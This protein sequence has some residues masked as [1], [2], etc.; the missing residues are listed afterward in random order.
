MLNNNE[1]DWPCYT[2]ACN[3]DMLVT[4]P[5]ILIQNV[6]SVGCRTDITYEKCIPECLSWYCDYNDHGYCEA[7]MVLHAFYS[8]IIYQDI[9]SPIFLQENCLNIYQGCTLYKLGDGLC[10]TECNNEW[11]AYDFGDCVYICNK[12]CSKCYQEMGDTYCLECIEGYYL[13]YGRCVSECYIGFQPTTK[14]GIKV[15]EPSIDISTQSN[16]YIIY[17]SQQILKTEDQTGDI[18]HP[19]SSLSTALSYIRYKYTRIYLLNYD[20]S[21]HILQILNMKDFSGSR[22][23]K[24]TS[25]LD[26]SNIVFSKNI[27]IFP[28]QCGESVLEQCY[29]PDSMARIL[30]R[31]L[32]A[33]EF[34]VRSTLS[35]QNVEFDGYNIIVS[36]DYGEESEYLTYC[37]FVSYDPKTG[38][39]F[40]DRGEQVTWNYASQSDC[41][42]YKN[43]TLF[44]LNN[45]TLN[46]TNVTFINWRAG[47]FSLFTGYKPQLF[48]SYVNFINIKTNNQ[49]YSAVLSFYDCQIDSFQCG[50]IRYQY[51]I[52][53]MLNSGYEYEDNNY[54]SGFL[55]SRGI[56]KVR[57]NQVNFEENLVYKGKSV[58]YETY[59]NT[60]TLIYA[61]NTSLFDISYSTFR[62]NIADRLFKLKMLTSYKEHTSTPQPRIE[63]FGNRVSLIKNIFSNI[64]GDIIQLYFYSQLAMITFSECRFE[65]I[66]YNFHLI[67]VRLYGFDNKSSEDGM[68]LFEYPTYLN[69]TE[70]YITRCYG[71]ASAIFLESLKNVNLSS[72]EID[73]SLQPWESMLVQDLIN[74]MVYSHLIALDHYISLP[75]QSNELTTFLNH[76]ENLI[77]LYNLVRL[78]IKDFISSNNY[79]S[80]G[81]TDLYLSNPRVYFSVNNCTIKHNFA[82][83]KRYGSGI[84]FFSPLLDIQ[85]SNITA[86]NNT[87]THGYGVV[88]FRN[89]NK[90]SNITFTVSD[91]IFERNSA[92]FGAGMAI[93]SDRAEIKNVRFDGNSVIGS[94]GGGIF[95]SPSTVSESIEIVI[96]YCEFLRN[97]VRAG[98]GGAIAID[99]SDNVPDMRILFSLTNSQFIENTSFQQASSIYIGNRVDLHSDSI[100]F[101]S[102]FTSNISEKNANI[103]IEH[104]SGVLTFDT[105]NFQDNESDQGIVMNIANSQTSSESTCKVIINHSS[106]VSN[107]PLS[108][109]YAS[110]IQVGGS[111]YNSVL[112][113]SFNTFSYNSATAF[114]IDYGSWT[115]ISSI[116]IDNTAYSSAIA[117]IT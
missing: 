47:F 87:N 67:D 40:N 102:N 23:S 2:R 46:L 36:S 64:Y 52:V 60:G 104:R 103:L 93:L 115:D 116:F 38:I 90:A 45:G 61:E 92:A 54:F 85:L 89:Y 25:P 101:N 50:M 82:N 88:F 4:C 105:C 107:R 109:P 98:Y 78:S 108:N 75:I 7:K 99:N 26:F 69:M 8:Q 24:P 79:S 59:D 17:V 35:I 5:V 70:V 94:Y 34:Y 117:R 76:S 10:D 22:L 30:W 9:Q 13:L 44:R 28:L 1:C 39:Y 20:N 16:P 84:S 43:A 72:L 48:L 37:P 63:I 80:M 19:F 55:Y 114:F 110:L 91:S 111:L 42:R 97:M 77:Y 12:G 18:E 49:P 58:Q 14:L 51:G 6:C 15:C 56:N 62:F 53:K 113:T 3:Y 96:S 11:C 57:I 100:I 41:D 74:D 32:D 71:S 29:M 65:D 21:P 68:L 31:G 66:I 106:F 95:F 73:H 27:E 83:S 81:G 86:F 112:E 33:I